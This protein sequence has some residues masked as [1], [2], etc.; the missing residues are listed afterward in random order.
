MTVLV[1]VSF[2]CF[3]LQECI[4]KISLW[5]GI[6]LLLVGMKT[7]FEMACWYPWEMFTY[8]FCSIRMIPFFGL[9]LQQVQIWTEQITL[10]LGAIF[11][12]VFWHQSE[13]YFISFPVSWPNNL[14]MFVFRGRLHDLFSQIE[15]EFEAL[16]AENISC[17]CHW[18]TITSCKYI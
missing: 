17:K 13:T 1:K 9:V 16:Y 15:K 3:S 8:L 6:F 4:A 7:C 18:L 10:G 11:L 2:F 5:F 14:A 12:Y